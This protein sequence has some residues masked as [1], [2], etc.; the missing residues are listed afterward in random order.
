MYDSYD[1]VALRAVWTDVKRVVVV[2]SMRDVGR[3]G[4]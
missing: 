3:F 1:A 4:R 2:V